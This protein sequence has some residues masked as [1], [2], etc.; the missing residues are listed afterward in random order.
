MVVI[1]ILRSQKIK[2]VELS[3]RCDTWYRNHREITSESDPAI[4]VAVTN[5]DAAKARETEKLMLTTV[6]DKP[7]RMSDSEKRNQK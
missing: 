1:G 5:S 4:H 6:A 3:R 2:L 7:V